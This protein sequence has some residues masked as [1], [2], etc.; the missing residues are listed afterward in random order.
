MLNVSERAAEA[1]HAT[2]DEN[3]NEPDDVLRIEQT[4][5]G[6]AL[7]I[8]SQRDGDQLIDH[9]D[10]TILAIDPAVSQALD[11]ATIDAVESQGG[12]QLVLTHEPEAE[13]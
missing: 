2:L 5:T 4:D 8:G 7:A 9:D 12:V 10:V 11:G 3:R 13:L 1:L 6:L